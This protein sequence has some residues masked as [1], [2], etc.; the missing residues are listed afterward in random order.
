MLAVPRLAFRG[1]RGCRSV[2]TRWGGRLSWSALDPRPSAPVR[3][4]PLQAGSQHVWP[5]R[6]LS[7]G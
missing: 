2:S 4:V 3:P 1:G 5:P 7:A 6:P